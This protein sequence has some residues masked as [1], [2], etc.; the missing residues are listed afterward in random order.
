MSRNPHQP[1]QANR[2]HVHTLA[3]IGMTHTDIGAIVGCSEK[4][5]RLYYREELN[6]GLEQANAAIVEALHR[7]IQRQNVT[8]IIFYEKCRGGRRETINEEIKNSKKSSTSV[9]ITPRCDLKICDSE[10]DRWHLHDVGYPETV[11]NCRR[12][13]ATLK[14]EIAKEKA[15][16]QK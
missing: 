6:D 8:A 15:I 5:L 3:S 11:E 4:T 9:V 16:A 12:A 14:A 7:E 13:I 10:L 1:T 2:D